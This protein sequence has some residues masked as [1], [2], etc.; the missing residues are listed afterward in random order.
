MDEIKKILVVED[1]SIVAMDIKNRLKSLNYNVVDVVDTGE[2]AVEKALEHSPDLI[3][4]DIMLK[5][6]MDGIQASEEIKKTLNLPVIFLT[7]YADNRTVERAKLTD[8]FGYLLKPFEQKELHTAIEIALYKHQMEVKLLKSREKYKSLVENINDV[9]FRLD[10]DNTISYVSPVIEK[11][12]SYKRNEIIGEPFS[13]FIYSSD[14]PKLLDSFEDLKNGKIYPSEYRLIDKDGSLIYVRS[15]SQPVVSDGKFSGLRGVMTDIT[16]RKVAEVA[17]NSSLKKLKRIINGASEIIVSVD[18]DG[19]INAWN[20]AVASKT[21]FSENE[22]RGKSILDEEIPE[23]ISS[24]VNLMKSTHQSGKS[25][26]LE[27]E[28]KDKDGNIRILLS[29]TS[30]VKLDDDEFGGVV[31]IGRDISDQRNLYQKVMPGNSYLSL[32]ESFEQISEDF[33]KFYDN[34]YALMCVSRENLGWLRNQF[35]YN[36]ELV[37]MSEKKTDFVKTEVDL[38]NILDMV[39]KYFKDKEK[40]VLL[41]NNLEYL[42]MM[43]GFKELIRFLYRLNDKIKFTNNILIVHLIEDCFEPTEVSFLKQEFSLFPISNDEVIHLD[44][45]KID[46]LKFIFNKSSFHFNVQYSVISSEFGLSRRTTKKWID[47]LQL[48]GLIMTKKNGRAK[49]IYLTDKGKNLISNY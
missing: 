41:L 7:A 19:K 30:T 35:S 38:D 1:E 17:L 23:E 27:H 5:G 21:G 46:I 10:A 11:M 4:M 48:K 26:L 36:T 42:Y 43:Y 29:N 3:L 34:N 12:L 8:P 49:Y 47:E 28:I 37:L 39:D 14:V 9:I 16:K 22:I 31:L 32:K 45:N 6:E 18:K 33:K 24:L 25:E 13:K 44:K 2:K 15:S 20:D 40:V